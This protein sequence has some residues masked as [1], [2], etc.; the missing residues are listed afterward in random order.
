MIQYMESKTTDRF[1]YCC[2]VPGPGPG[3]CLVEAGQGVD[4][5]IKK[6]T[7]PTSNFF[8]ALVALSGQVL[9]L[10]RLVKVGMCW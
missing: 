10:Y 2:Q 3:P 4:T 1:L 6:P 7:H 5:I 9:D 8:K